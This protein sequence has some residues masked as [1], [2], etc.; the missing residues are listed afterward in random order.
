MIVRPTA[1]L[2]VLNPHNELLLF[3][4]NDPNLAQAIF[5]V[6]P[7]GGVES[8]ETFALAAKRELFE[9]TGFVVKNV[10]QAVWQREFVIETKT[11]P[12]QIQ[13]QHFVVRVESS[14][15]NLINHTPLEQETILRHKWWS[16]EEL[17]RT[18]EIIY[19][20]ALVHNLPAI[21]RGETPAEPID[22]SV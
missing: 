12:W 7:G 14:N 20:Q 5:W 21:L 10:G 19:P 11:G 16:L 13:E 1:R 8:G 9:E 18:Q 4:C 15:L 22:I 6:T 2:L 17:Q 3:F